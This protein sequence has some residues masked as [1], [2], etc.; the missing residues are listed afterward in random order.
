MKKT[1]LAYLLIQLCICSTQVNW[2]LDVLNEEKDS[3][4]V[5]T[6]G[7]YTKIY[8]V[9]TNTTELAFPLLEEYKLSFKDSNI[10]SLDKD[11]ILASKENLIYSTYIGLKC[12][13]SIIGETYS[14]EINVNSNNEQM[15]ENSIEFS[16]IAVSINRNPIEI[17]LD[18]LL[19]SMPKNSFNLFKLKEEPYNVD[20]I[21][22][23]ATEIN[24]FDFENIVINSFGE[25]DL[26]Y[27]QNSANH[28]IIFDSAFG[29]NNPEVNLNDNSFTFQ[30]KL[31]DDKYNQC[32]KLSI[33][34]FEFSIEE[35][36]PAIDER[37]KKVIKYSFED[38]TE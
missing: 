31:A 33:D 32:Y 26:L 13:N 28:G 6:P 5:L 11:I 9:L 12:D 17:D 35:E 34:D 22:I 4:I 24:G 16:N 2:K 19:Y 7:K 37:L 29:L 3:K 15:D 27:E 21:R 18:I 25:R 20:E 1:F 38:I 30:I 36:I 14:I 23:K 8:F 10:I